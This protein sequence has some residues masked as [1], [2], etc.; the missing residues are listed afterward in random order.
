MVH[1]D[2]GNISTGPKDYY[3]ILIIGGGPAGLTAAIYAGRAGLSAAVF[4]KALEGGAVTQTHVVENWPG[5]IR[6]EGGELGE[7]FAEH[8]K[9]FGAEI[10]TAEVLKISYDNEYKYVELDNGKKVKGKVLIYATGAVPRKL[11]VPGEE[12][13]RGRGVTYCAACDGYLFSGKDIV[14]VGG[15]D[16]ACDEAHFLAKM[17]KSITMV[18]NLPYL[19]AAKVLQDRLLENKNVKVILNSLVKEIRGKDKVEEVVVVN[20]ETGEEKVIKAEGVFIYVGLVPKSD[21]LKDIVDINEYGYIKTDENME[22]NVP[23]IYAVGDVREK[24][25]RQIV[26]AAADGAIAVEHAA[27][28]Y[29]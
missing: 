28:K 4:E 18:Q 10:I 21:L 16:S 14:V 7:K 6:I 24:N 8:A 11:G 26:T 22:T 12:E 1:F 19:T 13:F 27:K 29:F 2:L 20:N 25:L 3:D 17:V 15:G 9:A 23:G 5:F